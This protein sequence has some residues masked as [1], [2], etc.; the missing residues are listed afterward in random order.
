MRA[1][2]QRAPTQAGQPTIVIKVETVVALRNAAGWTNAELA[3]RMRMDHSAVTRLL[4]GELRPANKSI[5]GFLFA[6]R[7]RF[8][9]IG[10]DDLFE[11]ALEGDE[12]ASL[13]PVEVDEDDEEPQEASA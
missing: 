4:G 12:A 13:A 3:R 8:P 1:D 2:Q 9:K 10:F 6:F 11:L 7:Q 5:A